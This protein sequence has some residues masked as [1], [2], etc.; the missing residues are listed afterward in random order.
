MRTTL[1]F[2]VSSVA[3]A[4][5]AAACAGDP[6]PSKD[7]AKADAT[8][9]IPPE[10]KL[11]A[12]PT[13]EPQE[14]P[15]IDTSRLDE[16]ERGVFWRWASQLYAPCPEVAVSVA[17]CVKEGRPCASCGPAARF[18]AERARS[19]DSQSEAIV[20]FTV[21][22]GPEVK[23]V[24]LAD[25]PAKGRAGAP[26][27]IVVWSD[28]EC[29]A[30][31]YAV[32]RIEEVA[33]KHEDEVRLVHKLY[34]LKSHTHS[35]PAARAALAAKKQG[36]YWEMEKQLFTHQK[37][38][39]DADLEGYAKEIGLDLARFRRDIADPKADEIIERDRAEADKHGLA[40]TP[41]IL[42]NGREMDLA[43][44]KIDRD[45]EPWIAMEVDIQRKEAE[46][47]AIAGVGA[48]LTG[49]GRGPVG[50][51]STG[52]PAATA[53][54]ATATATATGTATGGGTATGAAGAPKK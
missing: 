41:F 16:R 51:M 17:E 5:T 24:D 26:V 38:L 48:T 49:Q 53:V 34:P 54:P 47:R 11:L 33:S 46:L 3:I 7:A 1:I 25:S 44:F 30:C 20:A 42:I 37:A 39:E 50:P 45:L 6:H 36:K 22:F 23:K 40:G 19:G 18:L 32:P 10:T 29:P 9:A 35:L 52:V 31:G 13:S 21:R 14:L 8:I 4:V 2:F 15:G 27:T 43:L 12:A 28:Y